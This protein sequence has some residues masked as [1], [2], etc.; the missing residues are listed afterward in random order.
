MT[1]RKITGDATATGNG[2][3]RLAGDLQGSAASPKVAPTGTLSLHTHSH[4]HSPVGALL[5]TNNGAPT[6]LYPAN[7]DST[8]GHGGNYLITLNSSLT[9]TLSPRFNDTTRAGTTMDA[10]YYRE[11]TQKSLGLADL[12]LHGFEVG[13]DIN[14][15]FV[16]DDVGGWTP[17]IASAL[18]LNA[19][20]APTMGSGTAG[21]HKT[22]IFRYMGPWLGFKTIYVDS[23]W[24]T[25]PYTMAPSSTRS[26]KY[27]R[28]IL[29]NN[30][31]ARTTSYTGNLDAVVLNTPLQY[32][33]WLYNAGCTFEFN[34]PDSNAYSQMLTSVTGSASVSSAV[35]VTLMDIPHNPIAMISGYS[36]FAATHETGHIT[37]YLWFRQD[38]TG[39]G[40]D[41][42][43]D[44]VLA[45]L[46]AQD[47]TDWNAAAGL[48][49]LV[50][51]NGQLVGTSD[52]SKDTVGA[53]GWSGSYGYFVSSRREWI[54]ELI[55]TYMAY[56]MVTYYGGTGTSIPDSM[57]SCTN[58]SRRTA[59]LARLDTLFST[60]N[61]N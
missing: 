51:N 3:V 13:G 2:A 17:T 38:G 25:F 55:S 44:T 59:V 11:A 33:K 8:I 41:V 30:Y 56:R 31:A 9:F 21:Q 28:A 5:H 43:S 37:D 42:Q 58:P 35:G 61:T 6:T 15:T 52:Q 34:T 14:V 48:G 23:S 57:D 7:A 32:R 40:Y 18:S 26:G 50:Y 20:F 27:V 19:T 24:T 45:A 60:I 49:S 36:Q 1:Q 16:Q 22:A 46:Y 4:L 12:G 39:V 10:R 53:L 47:F 54:A 29:G